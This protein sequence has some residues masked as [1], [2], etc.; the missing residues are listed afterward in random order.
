MELNIEKELLSR[1]HQGVYGDLYNLDRK[2]FDSML[3]DAE[4]LDKEN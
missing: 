2:E 1:L 3:D 4:T